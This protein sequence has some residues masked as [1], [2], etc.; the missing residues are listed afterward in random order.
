MITEGPI[1]FNVSLL[2]N[3][4]YTIFKLVVLWHIQYLKLLIRKGNN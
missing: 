3:F 1:C 4:I 2:R